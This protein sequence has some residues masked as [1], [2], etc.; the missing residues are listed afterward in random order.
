MCLV[1]L[2]GLDFFCKSKTQ[3]MATKSS[4]SYGAEVGLTYSCVDTCK[5]RWSE[6]GD[7]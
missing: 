3:A 2:R 7:K 4:A 1:Y 5:T 6:V